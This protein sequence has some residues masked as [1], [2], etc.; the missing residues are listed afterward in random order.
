MLQLPPM[1]ASMTQ[2]K[3]KR[4][5]ILATLI[6]NKQDSHEMEQK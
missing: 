4:K 5:Q 1:N 3:E 2:F 6:E